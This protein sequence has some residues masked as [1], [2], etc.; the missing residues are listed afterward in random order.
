MVL[1]LWTTLAKKLIK[2]FL[3][4]LI[5]ALITPAILLYLRG[6]GSHKYVWLLV[7]VSNK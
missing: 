7:I 1:P 2:Y 5:I 4:F 3:L 6:K